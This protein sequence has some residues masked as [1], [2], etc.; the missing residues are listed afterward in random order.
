MWAAEVSLDSEIVQSEA[1]ES[2][3]RRYG[4]QLR[5][6]S[7]RQMAFLRQQ[8]AASAWDPSYRY[9]MPSGRAYHTYSL[10]AVSE[11]DARQMAALFVD[12]IDGRTRQSLENARQQL[13]NSLETLKE[14]P[15]KIEEYVARYKQLDEQIAEQCKSLGVEVGPTVSALGS[16]KWTRR[17]DE[18]KASLRALDI[19]R[20]GQLAR[21]CT[22]QEY[23]AQQTQP[24]TLRRLHGG[25]AAASQPNPALLTSLETMLV[26]LNVEMAGTQAKREAI[27]KDIAP[28]REI[29][30]LVDKRDEARDRREDWRTKLDNARRSV[31]QLPQRLAEPPASMRPVQVK[32]DTV[33]IVPVRAGPASQPSE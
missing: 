16:E 9:R 15:A 13:Q 2:W 6:L 28:W 19:E 10:F 30:E 22:I 31:E 21:L 26:E 4:T 24:A 5:D 32:D 1:A 12:H 11:E 3:I 17:F 25:E 20:A 27:E 23:M 8:V 18:V 14:A 29:L 33:R 7:A